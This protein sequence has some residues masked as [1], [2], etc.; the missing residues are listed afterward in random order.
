MFCR[1]CGNKLCDEAYVC[2]NC[3]CLANENTLKVKSS[4]ATQSSEETGGIE[5]LLLKIFLLTSFGLRSS[6]SFFGLFA[7]WLE[8]VFGIVALGLTITA[9]VFGL[10]RVKGDMWK[11]FSIFNFISGMALAIYFTF[12]MIRWSEYIF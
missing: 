8:I 10:K 5:E 9:F 1:N 2:P 6:L 4:V 3:G 7:Y 12:Y 11:W